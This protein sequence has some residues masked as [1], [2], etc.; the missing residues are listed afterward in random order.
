MED[1]TL[2]AE[3]EAVHATVGTVFGLTVKE[4]RIDDPTPESPG[5]CRLAKG[6]AQPADLAFDLA[7]I[8]VCGDEG[9]SGDRAGAR[10]YVKALKLDQPAFRRVA[11]VVADLAEEPGF[12]IAYRTIA[13]M[14][15]EQKSIGGEEVED[16][17]HLCFPDTTREWQDRLQRAVA[18]LD[19]WFA[20]VELPEADSI[21]QPREPTP[22]PDSL[23]EPRPAPAPTGRRADY[24]RARNVTSRLWSVPTPEA[25]SL[26][27]L[28]HGL[29]DRVDEASYV[30]MVAATR[31]AEGLLGE[32]T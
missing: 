13:Q 32:A 26:I 21:R 3:H 12:Q 5:W 18:S 8:M 14:L 1:L 16:I 2:I 29:M 19:A 7:P 30:S 4:V 17:V 15:L 6:P 9:T 23:V 11:G 25:R 10:E 22:S 31:Q 28:L 24:L 27:D 20:G